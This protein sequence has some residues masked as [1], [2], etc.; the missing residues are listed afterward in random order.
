V[1]V[2]IAFSL[3]VLDRLPIH[4][5]FALLAKLGRAQLKRIDAKLEHFSELA[6]GSAD[7]D[8]K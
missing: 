2:A 8:P 3:L 1:I 6:P 4:D 7:D 5:F